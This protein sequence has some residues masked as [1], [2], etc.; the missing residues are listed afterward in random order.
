MHYIAKQREKRERER[1]NAIADLSTLAFEKL[2]VTLTRSGNTISDKHR[3]ALMEVLGCYS[4]QPGKI[5]GV[6]TVDSTADGRSIS[7]SAGPRA[8][9]SSPGARHSTTL[10]TSAVSAMGRSR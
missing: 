10:A 9:A 4:S 6:R 8:R 2:L 1:F 7:A 5:P 3:E